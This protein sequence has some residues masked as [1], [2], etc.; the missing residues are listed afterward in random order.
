MSI[1]HYEVQETLYVRSGLKVKQAKD[2]VSGRRC[3]LKLV[4]RSHFD[5]DRLFRHHADLLVSEFE[6]Q[7]T[8]SP[9]FVWPARRMSREGQYTC[10]HGKTSAAAYLELDWCE[11]G[12]FFGLQAAFQ[13]PLEEDLA[14]TYFHQLVEALAYCHQQRVIHWNLMSESLLL[15][16]NY[17]LHLADFRGPE[18][19]LRKD[20]ETPPEALCG[21]VQS[22]AAVDVFCLGYVLFSWVFFEPPFSRAER[23]NLHYSKLIEDNVRFWSR[24]HKDLNVSAGL[25]TL[26]ASMLAFDPTQRPTISEIKSHPW[27]QDKLLASEELLSTVQA[28]YQLAQAKQTKSPPKTNRFAI[29]SGNLYRD[30]QESSCSWSGSEGSLSSNAVLPVYRPTQS[31]KFS[32]LFMTL[33]P[34]IFWSTAQVILRS[35]LDIVEIQSQAYK[36]KAEQVTDTAKIAFTVKLLDCGEGKYCLDFT[37][38][39]GKDFDFLQFYMDFL[40]LADENWLA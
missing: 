16:D 22:G 25:K 17:R 15:D 1:D 28:H 7:S 4:R 11:K 10:K 14:R 6:R 8:L 19:M 9:E 24:G 12:T 2:C 13:K 40:R 34:D 21:E 38:D 33:P 35:Q 18:K 26:L 39:A 36:L 30:S 3:L 37:Q 27:Y 20:A 32:Q 5:S 29:H 31:W 23:T